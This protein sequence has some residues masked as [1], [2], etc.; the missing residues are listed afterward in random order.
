ML[1]SISG[2]VP[3]VP[4][5]SKKSGHLYEKRLILKV[6]KETGRDPV[7]SEALGEDD[8]LELTSSQAVKPRPTPATSIPG[9]LSLFQNEWDST[10]LEVH[11][12]RQSLNTVRQ[13]LSHALYQHDAACRVIARLMRERDAYR[14]QLEEAQRAAPEGAANGKRGAEEAAEGAAKKAKAGI[15]PDIAEKLTACSNELS[16]GRKKRAISATVATPDDLAA[17]ALQSSHPLH[18]TSKGGILALDLSPAGEEVVATA[19]GDATV[20]VYD[21][22][23]ERFLASLTGHSKKVHD[24]KFVGSQEVLASA[25]ADKTTK[26][27]RAAG[28]GYDDQAGEV[29]SVCVHPTNDFLL[30]AAGDGSW[31]FYDVAAAQC[32]TQARAAFFVGRVADEAAGAGYSCAALHPDGLILCTGTA[33]AA[34]RIWETRTQKNVAKFD[35]HEGRINGISFSENGYYMATCAADGVKL[36][37][38]RKLRNFKSLAPYEEGTPTA[39][40]AF[41]HSGLYLG[42]GGADARIYGVKQDWGVV[43]EFADVPKKG[44]HALRFGADARS[45]LVGAADHNLRVF[46]QPQ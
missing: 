40:V 12:L 45:L 14:Q 39:A 31:A 35:G 4:V 21:C 26:L 36:W 38:L 13:E 11:Q 1:C 22:K 29:V 25:S 2:T 28:E 42:V 33:N 46:A 16:K 6:I 8:L 19:G 10:M 37:D 41:D 3:E 7:T 32:V 43:K 17:F 5:V 20:Q 27:W 24:V 44:V 23:A 34:V 15:T 18:K 9:L 30:T